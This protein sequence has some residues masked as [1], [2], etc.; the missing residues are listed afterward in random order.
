[1]KKKTRKSFWDVF[2]SDSGNKYQQKGG[3]N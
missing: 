3:E 1:M 2:V